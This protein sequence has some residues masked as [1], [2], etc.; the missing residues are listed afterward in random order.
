MAFNLAFL[1]RLRNLRTKDA[2]TATSAPAEQDAA[3]V[4]GSWRQRKFALPILGKMPVPQQ[5]RVLLA[6]LGASLLLGSLSVWLN[7]RTSS[8]NSLQTQIAGNALMHSQRLGKATPNAIPTLKAATGMSSSSTRAWS[9]TQSASMSCMSSIL[10]V[11]PMAIAV[12]TDRP[13]QPIA[14]KEARSA[15]MPTAPTG[16]V[17]LML[18][19]RGEV[20]FCTATG[21][22]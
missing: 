9:A 16:S 1:G 21:L 5:M 15:C 19:T 6:V 20:W 2:D 3:A 22:T 10:A 7:A 14:A 4:G 8:T 11:S 13:W 17:R 12:T 18:R